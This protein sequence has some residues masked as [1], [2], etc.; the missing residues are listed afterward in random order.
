MQYSSEKIFLI[1]TYVSNEQTRKEEKNEN[2]FFQMARIQ[3][4]HH[5]SDMANHQSRAKL[6]AIYYKGRTKW[7][8]SMKRHIDRSISTW[9]Q[10]Y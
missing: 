5:F 4:K 2:R 8:L 10:T 7:Q 1:N 3:E 6:L 9:T